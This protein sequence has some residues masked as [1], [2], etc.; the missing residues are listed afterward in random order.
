MLFDTH[1]HLAHEEFAADRREVLARAR[2]AGVGYILDTGWDLES[3][4]QA[5]A[6]A[7]PGEGLWAAV[8]V[9]AHH[10]AEA[11]EGYLDRLARL[12]QE[13]GVVAIGEI[14]LDYHYDFAPRPVQQRLFAEQLRLAGELGLPV[15]IHDREAHADTLA[16]LRREA[17]R[18]GRPLSG[19]MHCYSGSV[20]MLRDYLELGLH[21]GIGGPLTFKGARRVMEVVQAA[22]ATALVLETDCP[23]LA[24]VPYRGRRNEPAYVVKVAE[25]LAVARG[26]SLSE[27]AK[28]TTTNARRMLNLLP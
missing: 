6:G 16:A 13:P 20:E 25:A 27:V 4:Y 14:G 10:A 18:R 1:A 28:D 11:P 2:A 21:L 19:V 26:I 15:L 5:L 9:H 7:E 12:A 17:E 22:P 23:Y 24:P 3:S 8:G